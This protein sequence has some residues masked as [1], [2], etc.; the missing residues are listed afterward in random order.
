M[1]DIRQLERK[2][3]AKIRHEYGNKNIYSQSKAKP[4]K[5]EITES[6]AYERSSAA[7]INLLSELDMIVMCYHDAA[8]A[9]MVQL[10]ETTR[11]EMFAINCRSAFEKIEGLMAEHV[12]FLKKSGLTSNSSVNNDD[13]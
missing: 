13:L 12:D 7:F 2:L 8:E 3:N 10:K 11:S 9:F 5:P 6:R 4:A 1:K